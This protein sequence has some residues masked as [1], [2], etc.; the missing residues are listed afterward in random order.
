MP[1]P[2]DGDAKWQSE[3]GKMYSRDISVIICTYNR[4]ESLAVVLEDLEKQNENMLNISWELVL[5]DNNSTDRTKELVEDYK[6]KNIYC[7][8][9][10]FESIQG[11][12]FALNTGVQ[13]ANGNIIVFTDDDVRIDP[14]WLWKIKEVFNEYDCAGVGGRIVA[15][16]TF[17]KPKWLHTEGPNRLMG[18]IV[19]FDKGDKC[20]ELQDMPFGA[21]MAFKREIFEKYGM[22]RLDLGLWPGSKIGYE[23]TEFT[24]RVKKGGE[25]II[26]APDAIV[27]H[28][29]EKSRANKKYYQSWYF[30]FGGAQVRTNALPKGTI[31]YFGVPRYYFKNIAIATIRWIFTYNLNKRFFNKLM[32][33]VQAGQIAEAFKMSKEIR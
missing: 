16:W 22:F 1:N 4:A 9:Y 23:D 20:C 2:G 6:R 18:A 15:T 17:E 29:V 8:K 14:S 26:Y 24:L 30:G 19:Q 27:Y 5:V 28:P 12:S 32:V 10:L 13:A 33:Y 7:I 11:K 25:K 21:N 31:F 3:I